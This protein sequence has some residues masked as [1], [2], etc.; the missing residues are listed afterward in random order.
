GVNSLNI[1][2][3]NVE[4]R[5][6]ERPVAKY[7]PKTTYVERRQQYS[8]LPS[9]EV[10]VEE[11]RPKFKLENIYRESTAKE[12]IELESEQDFESAAEGSEPEEADL[13]RTVLKSPR[14]RKKPDRLG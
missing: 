3:Y 2:N 13:N 6:V 7:R 10:K 8:T 9:D 12:E 1:R 11:N 4:T 14:V 5:T